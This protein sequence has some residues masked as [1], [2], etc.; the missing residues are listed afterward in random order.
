[1]GYYTRFTGAI[2][3]APPVSWAKLRDGAF[4]P[5]LP[6]DEGGGDRSIQLVVRTEEVDT[7]DGILLRKEAI[8][9][10]PSTS[11]SMKAYHIVEELQ[12]LVDAVG[13]GY[14]FTGRIDCSG[15]EAGDLWRLAVV[16]GNATKIE[17]RLVW[18]D[19][20]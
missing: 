18:P 12:E 1:M 11:E 6:D 10:E 13:P 20:E 3:I 7:P 9:V 15:E 14:T 16:D 19:E 8:Q 17:P 4:T 2:S 5:F